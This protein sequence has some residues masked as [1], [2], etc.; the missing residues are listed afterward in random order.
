MI[1]QLE[2]V[3]APLLARWGGYSQSLLAISEHV[4]LMAEKHAGKHAIIHHVEEGE[5][6]LRQI[7]K[8]N[9]QQ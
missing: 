4:P 2:P 6:D 5:D 8:Q 3:G 9:I 7:G 1:W